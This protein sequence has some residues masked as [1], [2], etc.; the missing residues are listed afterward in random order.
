MKSLR[1]LLLGA[2][3][4]ASAPAL[5]AQAP[6]QITLRTLS[7]QMKFDLNEITVSPGAK[8]VLTFENPDDMPHNVAFCEPGTNLD[9]LVLKM[10][11]KPEQAMKNGFLPDDPKVWLKSRLLNPHEKQVIEFT[12]P[13]K[14]GSYPFVCTF[15]GHSATMKGN[16]RVLKQAPTLQDLKFALYLGA[17]KNLPDFSKL[18]PHRTGDVPDNLVQLNFDDYKNQFG[19]VFTG[20]L[21]FPSDGEHMFYVASDDGARLFVDGESILSADGVHPAEMREVKKRFRR[22][23]HTIRLEYFQAEGGA[24]LYLGWKPEG[25]DITPLSKWQ[26]PAWRQ[27]GEQKKNEFVGMPLSPADAPIIYRNFIAGAGNR[28]IG[29]G[30]PGGLNFAWSAESMN[31]ALA[32]RGAFID[33][34]RHWKNRG[35]GHQNPAGFDVVRPTDLVPPF[36]VLDTPE[37]KW[38]AL[39]PE[40]GAEDYEWKGYRLDKNGLPVFL[41]TWKGVEVEDQISA[42]GDFKS[43]GTLERKITLKGKLPANAYLLLARNAKTL[44]SSEGFSVQ[45]EKLAVGGVNYENQFSVRSEGAKVSGENLVVPA[46]EEIRIQYGWPAMHPAAASAPKTAQ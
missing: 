10:L 17:W 4:C 37:G 14:A 5:Q 40:K 35:G 41:Y 24:D 19:L 26:H 11:E 2:V 13:D 34:A 15:P 30:M 25:H 44:P 8:V 18:T 6:V 27:P 46:K 43:G 39:S 3:L 38:P 31:L 28:G 32:W 42:K 21:V 22:G 9:Q 1:P 36:A 29:V 16:L 23:E 20:K 33:A 12:A 45:G 7:A